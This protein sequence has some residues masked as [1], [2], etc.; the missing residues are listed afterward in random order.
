M[1]ILIVEDELYIR[2][3][4]VKQINE[5]FNTIHEVIEAKN[6]IKALDVINEQSVDI[7]LTDIK[8]PKMN[9]IDLIK[10]ISKEHANIKTAVFSGY[11]DFHYAK[12]ALE[13][14]A[15]RFLLKPVVAEELYNTINLLSE[16]IEKEE[17]N[18]IKNLYQTKKNKELE[19]KIKIIEFYQMLIGKKAFDEK[20]FKLV[21]ND[22]EMIFVAIIKVNSKDYDI[23]FNKIYNIKKGINHIYFL[24]ESIENNIIM[25]ITISKDV[26]YDN[27]NLY[28]LNIISNRDFNNI[29]SLF[30][31][32]NMHN[33]K[34]I[35]KAYEEALV[36]VNNRFSLTNKK[37]IFY[38]NLNFNTDNNF[39]WINEKQTKMIL[40]NLLSN[41]KELVKG[42]INS[43]FDSSLSNISHDN[44]TELYRKIIT[45][46]NDAI[47]INLNEKSN[48]DYLNIPNIE[49]F[50]DINEL[51]QF[52]NNYTNIVFDNNLVN[53][54]KVN[55]ID[56][57]KRYIKENYDKDISLNY[58]ANN[59][60]YLHPKYLSN[61]FKKS[62][63]MTF[64]SYL[65]QIRMKK[66]LYLLETTYM[67]ISDV[68]AYS[69]YNNLSYFIKK[70][71]SYYN[72][73]PKEVRKK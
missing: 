24:S 21:V 20:L 25:F 35:N 44:I 4:I 47:M 61:I 58:L 68:S 49:S 14:G 65:T 6:G 64:S 8:M 19:N 27:I 28:Y 53:D 67:S 41:K 37:Y 51:K 26:Y 43:I 39:I 36:A 54:N 38:K 30:G 13:S 59:R 22:D 32:S 2:K 12:G 71:K 9:G 52:I 70:F 56:D 55:V 11:A 69:G 15:H 17:S 73:T 63:G 33:D 72:I 62:T 31:I 3:A 7:V 34:N 60:Y 29:K 50:F 57:I 18:K 48:S 42:L 16:E 40:E 5:H 23:E 1:K 45:I 66:A 46:I 10:I